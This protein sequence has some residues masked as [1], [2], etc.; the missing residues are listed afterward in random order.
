MVVCCNRGID[1]RPR[2]RGLPLPRLPRVPSLAAVGDV[3]AG[4]IVDL[5]GR[6]STYVIDSGPQDGPTYVLLHS[7]ACTGLMTWYPALDVIRCFG[8]VVVFDQRWHGQGISS[9]RFLLEDCADDVVALAD[10]L[11]IETFVPVGYSMGSLVAQLIWKRHRELVDGL[12]LCAATT[13][14]TRASHERLATGI[15]AAL[16]DAF[17]PPPTRAALPPAPSAADTVFGV[18]QWLF[19][20]VRTTSPG[21]IT[22]VAAE[23]TRFNSTHWISD[24][25]VP[26]SVLITLRDRIFSARRQRWLA[27]QIPE[28][29]TVTVDAGHA[30]C[31]LQSDK[32]VP[33]LREAISLVHRRVQVGAFSS[34]AAPG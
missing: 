5:P 6:G 18:P 12:V 19:N 14:V 31:T 15:F 9:P 24:I 25:D 27:S 17:I 2:L 21:A 26:T 13:G 23:I 3:S 1:D 29:H 10:A 8:R 4:R 16:V 11:G 34:T 20:Q 28:A 30:G 33:G 22:R 32:F 7:L